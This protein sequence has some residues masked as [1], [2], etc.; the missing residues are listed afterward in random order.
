MND[1][2]CD[3]VGDLENEIVTVSVCVGDL[4]G[5]YP[6]LDR[7]MEISSLR[8]SERLMSYE[9]VMVKLMS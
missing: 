9:G 3:T 7:D 6:V 2:V 5:E 8:V 4:L 1:L